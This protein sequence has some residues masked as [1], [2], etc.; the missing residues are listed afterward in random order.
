M[1]LLLGVHHIGTLLLLVTAILLLVASISSPVVNNLALLKVDFRDGLSAERVTF[2]SFGY[3]EMYDGSSDYCNRH[4]GYNPLRIIRGID[5]QVDNGSVGRNTASGLTRVMVLHPVGAVLSFVGFLLAVI[6]THVI[7]S[8]TASVLSGLT[9]IVTVVALAC[10]FTALSIVHH[11]VNE[12]RNN[13]ATYGSALWCVV[14]A[15]VT[16]FFAT[17]IVFLSCCAS[18]RNKNKP[19][20]VPKQEAGFADS[21]VPKKKFWQRR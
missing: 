14:A 1:G 18:K 17:I 20:P 11:R 13:H 19:D 6:G 16:S 8:F 2:G 21:T 5:G 9:F 15:V 12:I 7:S 10:D 3:C 4:L